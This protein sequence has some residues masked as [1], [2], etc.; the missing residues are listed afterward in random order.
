MNKDEIINKL[1][2]NQINNI[3]QKYKL[4]SKDIIRFASY[5]NSDPFSETECCKWLGAVSKSTNQTNYI[6][7]WFNKKKQ[8]LHRLLYINYTGPL[9]KNRY[10]RFTCPNTDMKGICCN[11]KHIELI[12]YN[13]ETIK[14][15]KPIITTTNNLNNKN[16][17]VLV[18]DD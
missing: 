3:E 1:F 14:K 18:F 13:T 5:I 4:N 10:L 16:I 7:F 2:S 8:A 15:E 9:P 17:F 11:I 12:N 6:N